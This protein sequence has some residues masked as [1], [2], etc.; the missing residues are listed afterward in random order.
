[1]NF[2]SIL[3]EI[4]MTQMASAI[5]P[6]EYGIVHSLTCDRSAILTSGNNENFKK[7]PGLVPGTSIVEDAGIN[8]AKTHYI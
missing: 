4:P 1:M 3:Q 8:P 2:T 7:I 5:F 6:R